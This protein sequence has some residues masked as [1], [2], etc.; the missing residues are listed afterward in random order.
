MKAIDKSERTLL[1]WVQ[2]GAPSA[3][4]TVKLALACGF[5]EREAWEIARECFPEG[6]RSA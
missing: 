5:D 1:L 2:K 6:Q 3:E 4:D